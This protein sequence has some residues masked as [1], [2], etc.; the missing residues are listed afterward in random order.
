MYDIN[1][2]PQ[3]TGSGVRKRERGRNCRTAYV[4][5]SEKGVLFENKGG[6]S[7]DGLITSM[8]SVATKEAPGDRSKER[9]PPKKQVRGVH[10]GRT[11]YDSIS[12]RRSLGDSKVHF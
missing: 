10:N 6:G 3:R 2:I 7:G 1:S 8:E 12:R 5:C 11:A 9:S 4:L